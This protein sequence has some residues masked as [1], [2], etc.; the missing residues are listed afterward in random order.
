MSI[1]AAFLVATLSACQLPQLATPE[2]GSCSDAIQDNRW[3]KFDGSGG[4]APV[5]PEDDVGWGEGL[6]PPD[7]ELPDQFG[8]PTCLWQMIG[9]YVVVDVSALWCGPCQELAKHQACS[10]EAYGDD[11]MF[12]TLLTE[13]L[14]AAPATIEHAAL[15]S[16]TFGLGEGT[17]TPVIA[18]GG[19]VVASG[20]S[21]AQAATLPT[22]LLLDRDL[23]WRL[24]TDNGTLGDTQ[25]R[26]ILDE[27]TGKSADE[28]FVEGTTAR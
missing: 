11:V 7:F 15:W 19:K 12:M 6:I 14:E 21:N 28:C 25:V 17:L 4:V 2:S 23:R 9:R 16:E 5:V 20:F 13:D 1:R 18:D 22:L 10:Q 24:R 8:D 26:A 3:P 27:E